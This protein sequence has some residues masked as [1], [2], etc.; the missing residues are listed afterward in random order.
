MRVRVEEKDTF[1]EEIKH[2]LSCIKSSRTPLTSGE[3]ER[4]TLAVVLAGYESLK[5]GGAPIRVKY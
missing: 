1:T 4:K 3:E 5:R 2:F